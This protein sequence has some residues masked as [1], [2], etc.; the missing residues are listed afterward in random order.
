[1]FLECKLGEFEMHSTTSPWRAALALAAVTFIGF[2]F[3]YGLAATGISQLLFPAQANGSLLRVGDRIVGSEWIA[4]PFAD[5]R[6][7]SSRPSAANY[8][9]MAAAGSNM[10]LTHPDFLKR[11][12]ETRAAIRQRE[13]T[14]DIPSDLLTQSGSGLDP[15][16]SPDAALLQAPRIATA[17]NVPVNSVIEV[18]R[19]SI[20]SKTFGILGAERVNVLKLNLALDRKFPAQ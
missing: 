9:P 12:E 16:L 5:D 13:G 4:Q 3:L 11:V 10:A 20:E 19:S 8:D 2:A 1:M 6:Y 7:V 17:R 18:I 14:L 15:H